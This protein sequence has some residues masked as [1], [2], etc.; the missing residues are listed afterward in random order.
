MSKVI[1]DG[2]EWFL[3]DD[4]K[5]LAPFVVVDTPS[6]FDLV[7]RFVGLE[8]VIVDELEGKEGRQWYPAGPT[9]I[10][11]SPTLYRELLARFPDLKGNRT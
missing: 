10:A 8:L 3:L 9:S 2:D 5:P 7:G 4:G 1:L 6:I 11:V